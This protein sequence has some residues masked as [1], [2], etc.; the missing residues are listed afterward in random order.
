MVIAGLTGGIATGKSTVAGFLKEA[1]ARIICA[2]RLARQVVEPGQPAYAEIIQTFGQEIILENGQINREA[3]GDLVFNDPSARKRLDGIVHPHVFTAM[4]H[5]IEA[6]APDDI[7]ILDIPLLIETGM[8]LGL[9]QVILVYTPEYI[10][11]KRLMERDGIGREAAMAR[12]R[13]QM[14]IEQKRKH[15][16]IVIDNSFSL[17][18]TRKR[19]LEVLDYLTQNAVKPGPDSRAR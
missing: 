10:Q 3:L 8:H 15:A 1:G 17:A 11:L 13:A 7:V 14:P 18:D 5:R 16:T 9:E 12:I 6:A 2:D 4:Q 19:S